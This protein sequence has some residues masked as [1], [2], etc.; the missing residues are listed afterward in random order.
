MLI[1]KESNIAFK[2]Y[3]NPADEILNIE[4]NNVNLSNVYTLLINNSIGQTLFSERI[5]Q[6]QFFIDLSKWAV[7][8]IYKL[9]IL[10]NLGNSIANKIIVVK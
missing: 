10:D 4:L 1:N 5:T 7:S 6:E 9:D 2:V 8:G 3:P